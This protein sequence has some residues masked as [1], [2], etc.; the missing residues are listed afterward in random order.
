MYDEIRRRLEQRQG[1]FKRPA[2]ERVASTDAHAERDTSHFADH[3]TTEL[4]RHLGEMYDDEDAAEAS[5]RPRDHLLGFGGLG[6]QRQFQKHV[7]ERLS[8]DVARPLTTFDITVSNGSRIF[9]P[10]YDRDW[11]EGNGVGVFSRADGKVFSLPKANGFS[12]AGTG[13]SVVR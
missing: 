1:Q 13:S 12:A 11:S 7:V 10:P 9:G 6:T 2:I 4:E 5:A 3:V 8:L